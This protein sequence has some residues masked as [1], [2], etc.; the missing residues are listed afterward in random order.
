M[1]D[2]I[3]GVWQFEHL[4]GGQVVDAWEQSNLITTE[5]R[6]YLLSA[7]LAA[8]TQKTTWYVGLM[9]DNHT[10]AA[11]D[12]YAT[13]GFTEVTDYDGNRP[14][15]TPG[16]VSA[17]SVSNTASKAVFTFTAGDT[18]YGAGLFSYV[19]KAD[20]SQAGAVLFNEILFTSPR[21]V[22]NEDVVRVTLTV[23]LTAS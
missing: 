19:T 5:G 9:A 14:T 15:W 21:E 7:G 18:L 13:P 20:T 10:P 17:G 23:T 2:K 22:L 3:K 4:R 8:G 11:G 6:N 16:S 1:I 12:T